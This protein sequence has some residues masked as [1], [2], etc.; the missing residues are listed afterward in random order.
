[1][2]LVFVFS[3]LLFKHYMSRPFS[4]GAVLG[5]SELCGLLF[6]G[7]DIEIMSIC[8]K[9]LRKLIISRFPILLTMILDLH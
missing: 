9:L 7:V 2:Q 8:K 6:V 3:A 4:G 1:M 5:F